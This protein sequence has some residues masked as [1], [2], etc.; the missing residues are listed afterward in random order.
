MGQA[1]RPKKKARKGLEKLPPLLPL[2][3][4]ALRV[5]HYLHFEYAHGRRRVAVVKAGFERVQCEA[6]QTAGHS[7]P[8]GQKITEWL[9]R[10]PSL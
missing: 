7:S 10:R 9:S 6:M 1:G 3:D 8:W 5:G 4:W 2:L